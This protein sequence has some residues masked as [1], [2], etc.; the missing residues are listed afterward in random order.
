MQY[1]MFNLKTENRLVNNQEYRMPNYVEV[2]MEKNQCVNLVEK[3]MQIKRNF[4]I[5]K[6]NMY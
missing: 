1:L 3:T 4:R 6:R 5:V 2:L